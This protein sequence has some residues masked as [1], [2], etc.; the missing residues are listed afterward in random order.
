M[1]HDYPREPIIVENRRGATCTLCSG[2][3]PEFP[4]WFMEEVKALNRRLDEEITAQKAGPVLSR[5][6]AYLA[7]WRRWLATGQRCRALGDLFSAAEW[8]LL[9]RG[10][11][12]ASLTAADE[13][14][15]PA[16]QDVTAAAEERKA[17]TMQLAVAWQELSEEERLPFQQPLTLKQL[18]PAGG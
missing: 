12:P 17:A 14:N 2:D 10:P 7:A 1:S 4:P 9:D 13:S 5:T 3:L 6:D 15:W 18:S 8:A 16:Y 11:L